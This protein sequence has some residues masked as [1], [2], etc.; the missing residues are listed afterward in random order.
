MITHTKK[1]ITLVELIV[2]MTLTSIFAVLCVMLIN[3][4]ER[5]YRS[6]LKLARAQLLADTLVDS[7]RKECDDVRHEE[8]AD[9]W[10][11]DLSG[12][13]D[14]QLTG[15]EHAANLD[16][17]NTLVFRR[18]DNY[19]EA[20]YAAVGISK[21]KNQPDVEANPL[22]PGNTAHS[23]DTLIDSGE[24]NLAS[25]IVHFGYY[26][27]KEDENGIF[28]IQSYDYTNPVM[29]K[30]Y[31]DFR[32]ELKFYDLKYKDGEYPAYVMCKISIIDKNGEFYT[33]SAVLSFAAN[34]SGKGS[35]SHH[36]I[37]PTLRDFE[38]K[39]VWNDNS[40]TDKR[41][42]NGLTFTLRDNN[43]T[44]L[45]I[46]T[47][48]DV[49]SSDNQRFVFKNINTQNG[50]GLA[51]APDTIADYERTITKTANGYIVKYNNTAKVRLIPGPD[52]NAHV[53][54]K[55]ITSFIF[56]K[57]DDYKSYLGS[58]AA[59]PVAERKKADGT[60]ETVS[61]YKLYIVPF[62]DGSKVAY[63][64][65][66]TGTFNGNPIMGSM[67][68]DCSDVTQFTGLDYIDTRETEDMHRMFKNCRKWTNANNYISMSTWNTSN[69]KAFDSMFYNVASDDSITENITIDVR[70]F[71]FSNAQYYKKNGGD[72]KEIIG[73]NKMFYTDYGKQGLPDYTGHVGRIIFK[74]NHKEMSQ[75]NMVQEVFAGCDNL[76]SLENF[77]DINF[78]GVKYFSDAFASCPK[79]ET[80]DFS[81]WTLTNSAFTSINGAFG[82]LTGLKNFTINN[83]KIPNVTDITGLF[84]KLS[85]LET[86]QI[87]NLTATS[88]TSINN[89]L[90]NRTKLT[91]AQMSG[92]KLKPQTAWTAQYVFYGCTS[93]DEVDVTGLVDCY[94]T[95][96][97][98]IFRN[99][100]T[101]SSIKGLNTWVT[102]GITDFSR[103]FYACNSDGTEDVFIIDISGFEF[104]QS[105]N[106]DI[107]MASMFHTC[108]AT[109]IKFPASFNPV[110][111]K[112]ISGLF[113]NCKKLSEVENFILSTNEPTDAVA[114]VISFPNVTAVSNLFTHCSGFKNVK[115]NLDLPR[116]STISNLVSNCANLV[117]LDV[118]RSNFSEC[119]NISNFLVSDSSLKTLYM[120]DIDLSKCTTANSS[121]TDMFKS[122]PVNYLYMNRINLDGAEEFSFFPY[123]TLKEVYLQEASLSAMTS[124]ERRFVQK[125][126]V[127][128]FDISYAK[129]G[130]YDLGDNYLSAS[131]MF[132]GCTSLK[133][134]IAKG[135]KAPKNLSEM[136]SGCTSLT[137][138]DF[139]N[140][141]TAKTTMM[142]KMFYNCTSMTDFSNLSAFDTSNVTT[143]ASMFE[144]CYNMHS[145]DFSS[146]E[147]WNTSNVTTMSRMF[148]NCAYH[149]NETITAGLY[150]INLSKFDFS[151]VTDF[152]NMFDVGSGNGDVDHDLIK[153]V[154]LPSNT[155]GNPQALEAKTT[156]YMFR[157]RSN[158][159]VL[160]NLEWFETDDS[161]KQARG[162][163]SRSGVEVIDIR[164][165]N[166]LTLENSD[167]GS[168]YIFDNCGSLKTIIV[169]SGTNCNISTF[170]GTGFFSNCE[171]LVGGNGTSYASMK[172]SDGN[173]C[174][175]KKY[176]VVD[177]LNGNKGYFTSPEQWEAAGH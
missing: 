136:F 100:T 70:N 126:N 170:K 79:V 162:M 83:L 45:G 60:Y 29:A 77:N 74:E 127:E 103:S 156:M 118:S 150:D 31:G 55:G 123:S 9:V 105:E 109:K 65:S 3:P 119:S 8:K 42:E 64:L 69:V 28:P 159:K 18:N 130:A 23:I 6:T 157:R 4:I 41:P 163:F 104:T 19:T 76:T 91:N 158:L 138:V 142:N 148:F 96:I 39:V 58:T 81:N 57:Y 137:T 12:A 80:V 101:L 72:G 141:D 143:M 106:A 13:D 82:G 49:R 176:A 20:I 75:L 10:I 125:T 84:N 151:K 94:C 92:M 147:K 177:G 25:G 51:I 87:N 40:A 38:V 135:F 90:K 133:T 144:N 171:K 88:A 168:A 26:Q 131:Q 95:D 66:D 30:T 53:K 169:A 145:V 34:G 43:S 115:M 61:D 46:H 54:N 2:A 129:F 110:R 155:I 27:A 167:N 68:M 114:P 73:I 111:V 108:G 56:G 1:G 97:K 16:S 152:S 35:G 78:S 67:F 52:F 112:Y 124:L 15:T 174:Q 154:I 134:V 165:I 59:I 116:C 149:Q 175:K 89:W 113:Q 140:W 93:L 139:E 107:D 63:V 33:R 22:T 36:P 173:N 172:T 7:I 24:E 44:L 121:F 128:L 14:R 5:T 164:R 21:D 99:C 48:S 50:Y 153:K 122:T 37:T 120:N 146:F 160:E 11:T 85:N 102:S 132:M 71:D 117:S 62:A 47:V 161:L 86:V 166:L 98:E 17:G 32:V